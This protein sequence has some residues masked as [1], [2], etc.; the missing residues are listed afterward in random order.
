M[1]TCKTAIRRRKQMRNG[2][3][4]LPAN[5]RPHHVMREPTIIKGKKK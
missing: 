3:A 2:Y 5:K 1:C 4:H